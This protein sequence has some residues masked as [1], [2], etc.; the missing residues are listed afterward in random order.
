MDNFIIEDNW[1]TIT[2]F[3]PQDWEE[4]AFKLGALV[5]K[6][7]IKSA[8]DLLRILLMYLTDDNSLKVTVA[9]AKL[10]DLVDI[11]DVALLKKLKI[12][13]EWFRWMSLEILKY[14]GVNLTT[15]TKFSKY[16]IISID[17]SV[18]SEPGSTGTDWRLHYAI[19]LFALKCVQFILSKQDKGESFTNFTVNKNDLLIGDRAYG[20]YKSMK[21]L[22]DQGAFFITRFK[23]KAFT[24]YDNQGKTFNMSEKV[25]NLKVGEILEFD[26]SICS[27][28]SEKLDI[29]F[30]IIKKSKKE[31]DL[32]VKKAIKEQKKK[33]R[34][35]DNTTIELHRYIILMTNLPKEITAEEILELYRY[36]WQIEIAFKRLKSI[37][38]LGHLPKKDID[39]SKGW[40]QGKIFIATLTQMIADES[41]LFSP[42]GY[43]ML[44][45]TNSKPMYME[46]AS[47]DVFIN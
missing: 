27:E 26:A 25:K 30:C 41:Y 32:A 47:T 46:R 16:N 5:R 45:T 44:A 28:K 14:R 7:K 12:S 2:K 40:L 9:K 17:A 15:P 6:R 23:N 39:S 3:L 11:S 42:W 37:F 29:R 22:S 36:R 13:G 10:C 31:G 19:D 20:R 21:Y 33:Q 43:P 35:I 34:K 24:M 18:I 8:S 4:K 38:G 1:E